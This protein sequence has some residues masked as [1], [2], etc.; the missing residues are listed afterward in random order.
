MDDMERRVMETEARSKSNTH[1]IDDLEE[2]GKVLQKLATSVELLAQNMQVMTEEQKKQGE[3]LDALE[4]EPGERWNSMKRTIFTTVTS[5]LA[6]G[7]VGA[8]MALLLK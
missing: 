3:R 8:L 6:G 1:R 2:N 7:L 5:T 4:K